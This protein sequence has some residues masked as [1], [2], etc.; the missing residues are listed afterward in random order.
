MTSDNFFFKRSYVIHAKKKGKLKK[1]AEE[2]EGLI[3]GEK[4]IFKNQVY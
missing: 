2:Q 1:S 3:Y 4:E